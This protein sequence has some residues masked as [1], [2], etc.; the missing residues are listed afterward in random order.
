MPDNTALPSVAE[1]V[2]QHIV[3]Q[4]VYFAETNL[5]G[6]SGED[7][8]GIVYRSVKAVL[9]RLYDQA[10]TSLDCPD[11]VDAIAKDA[12]IPYL[13]KLIDET[14]KRFNLFGW[15]GRYE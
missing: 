1:Q 13:S 5:K 7:K 10:D 8:K 6:T 14:V 11:V 2:L 4:E 15:G 9:D 12:L 3:T